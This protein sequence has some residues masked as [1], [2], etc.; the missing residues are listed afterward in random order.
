MLGFVD[1]SI[2]V[3]DWARRPREIWVPLHLCHG[4]CLLGYYIFFSYY[5]VGG[6]QAPWIQGQSLSR[7]ERET[8]YWTES[9]NVAWMPFSALIVESGVYGCVHICVCIYAWACVCAYICGGQ[10]SM[11]C[12][13]LNLSTLDGVSLCLELIYLARYLASEL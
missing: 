9:A 8:G 5:P 1:L 12:V 13:P 2:T 10:M 6:G 7:L 4:F 3:S 11:L